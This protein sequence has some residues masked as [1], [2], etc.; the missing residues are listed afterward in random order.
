MRTLIKNGTIVTA[1]DQYKGDVLVEGEK[2]AV[3]GTALDMPA[4]VDKVIDATGKYVL[5]GGIDVHTHLDM[6]FGGTTS[7]DDFETGTTRR[8]VRRHDDDR[9][10]RD[11]VPRPDAAPR[12]GNVDEEGR[13]QGGRSTTAST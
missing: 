9:R 6:P 5:P 4:D 2:I 13:G 10:L 3:I 8:G 1:T 12:L 7:A 11:P